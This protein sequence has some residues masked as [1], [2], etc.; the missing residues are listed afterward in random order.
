M[1]IL[2]VS[3]IVAGLPLAQVD[4]SVQYSYTAKKV[5]FLVTVNKK[6]PFLNAIVP[7]HV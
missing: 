4:S 7:K 2:S 1:N 3:K 5:V 6:F